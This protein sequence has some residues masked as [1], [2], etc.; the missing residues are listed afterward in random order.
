MKLK[1]IIKNLLIEKS[2]D[3][4]EYGCAMLY[5][6]FPEIFKIH[7]A[8][9]PDDVY[10]AP[11]GDDRTYGIEDEPHTTLLFG[12]HEEVNSMDII[13]VLDKFTFSKCIIHNASL[14]DN[15]EYDVLKFDVKGESLHECNKML[16]KLPHTNKF[17]DYHPHLTI[18]YIKKGL[19]EKYVSLFKDIEFELIP[20]FGVYSTAEGSKK[21][22]TI[23]V[24]KND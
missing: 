15:P 23:K 12:L 21:K 18:A 5:F 9:D 6:N 19:G 8:I 17:P 4:Y 7:D 1:K 24:D 10:E 2:G 22:I 11:E 16:R 20:E 13:N 14:F 3:T